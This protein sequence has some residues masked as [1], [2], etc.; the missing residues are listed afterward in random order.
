MKTLRETL[1]SELG[2]GMSRDVSITAV[3]MR[4]AVKVSG[5]IS[6]LDGRGVVTL[7]DIDTD[8]NELVIGN[9]PSE[10]DGASSEMKCIL[11]VV[12]S[13]VNASLEAGNASIELKMASVVVENV[14]TEEAMMASE[15]DGVKIVNE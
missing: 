11:V 9:I 3:D 4:E 14:S 12:G 2:M 6:L 1:I 10:V 13:G 8:E 5:N 7:E 15:D